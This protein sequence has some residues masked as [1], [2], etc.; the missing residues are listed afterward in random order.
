MGINAHVEEENSDFSKEV[1][2]L[3]RLGVRLMDCTEGG[4][5]VNNG[6]ESS[7]VS[8]MKE[9]KYQDPILLDFK[10]NFHKQ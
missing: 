1:H 7:L 2:R 9:K 5:V 4:I 8:E 6:A 3:T 10:A